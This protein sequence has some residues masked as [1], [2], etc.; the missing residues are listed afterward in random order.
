MFLDVFY[1]NDRIRKI[2][3]FFNI[4]LVVWDIVIYLLV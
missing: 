4:D 2:K 1:L 3:L